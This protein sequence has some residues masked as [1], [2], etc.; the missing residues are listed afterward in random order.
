[1]Y[2]LDI[3]RRLGDVNGLHIMVDNLLQ[4]HRIQELIAFTSAGGTPAPPIKD[5]RA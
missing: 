2:R 3:Y 5:L 4:E 1:M